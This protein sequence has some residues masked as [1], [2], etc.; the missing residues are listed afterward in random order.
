MRR[1]GSLRA[2]RRQERNV[3]RA[4]DDS[5]RSLTQRRLRGTAKKAR[6]RA[7]VM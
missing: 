2:G 1:N 7:Q 3:R 4:K 6:A 5:A